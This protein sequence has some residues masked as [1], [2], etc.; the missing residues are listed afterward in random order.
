[1]SQE[2]TIAM[3]KTTQ[4][5]LIDLNN[6]LNFVDVDMTRINDLDYVSSIIA[7]EECE[8]SYL[9]IP[10]SS[11]SVQEVNQLTR[12]VISNE[13]AQSY[14][15]TRCS[16]FLPSE[17]GKSFVFLLCLNIGSYWYYRIILR[18]FKGVRDTI[19]KNI[20]RF[21]GGKK[22][23]KP[24]AKPKS[25]PTTTTKEEAITMLSSAC[26]D[27]NKSTEP[28]RNGLIDLEETSLTSRPPRELARDNL[29]KHAS[30]TN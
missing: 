3:L 23:E 24:V 28:K 14:Y 17:D 10:L 19:R 2:I 6:A 27:F 11:L 7:V 5:I 16:K 4:E 9:L 1:M 25:K 20:K 18:N 8:P 26:T 30:L 21:N 22:S 15:G 13:N 29:D 12:L